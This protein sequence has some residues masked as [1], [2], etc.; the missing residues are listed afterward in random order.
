MRGLT[1]NAEVEE[2][3]T[4]TNYDIWYSY[5][6]SMDIDQTEDKRGESETAETERGGISELTER[7]FMGFWVKVLS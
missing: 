7:A 4:K 1:V 5:A 3:S 2:I 6:S